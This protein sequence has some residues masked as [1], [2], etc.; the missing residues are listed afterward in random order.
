MELLCFCG[1]L[2]QTAEHHEAA[3]DIFVIDAL[4]LRGCESRRWV[5]LSLNWLK[6]VSMILVEDKGK[7]SLCLFFVF[8]FNLTS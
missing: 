4:D 1:Y 5:C 2:S 7:E 8:V 6:L 3:G